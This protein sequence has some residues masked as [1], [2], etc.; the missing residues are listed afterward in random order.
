MRFAL[1]ALAF[2]A[3]AFAAPAAELEPPVR[4][5]AGDAYID[6]G[7]YIAHSGPSVMD[8]DRDGRPDLV[9]GNFMGHFQ[10]YLNRG[11]RE[12]PVYEDKGLLQVNGEAAKIPN[13]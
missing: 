9:V 11:T 1:F 5:K 3:V 4:L 10:V 8:L 7:K 2:T 12:A 6:S 13:W